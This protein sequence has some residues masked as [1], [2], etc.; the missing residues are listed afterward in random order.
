MR[1]AKTRTRGW[2]YWSR[3]FSNL[4]VDWKTGPAQMALGTRPFVLFFREVLGVCMAFT[5]GIFYLFLMTIPLVFQ[6]TYDQLPDIAGLH[7]IAIS[8]AS[9]FN[10]RAVDRIYA[11]LKSRN[12]DNGTPEYRLRAYT[13]GSRPQLT[14]NG[15]Y[16][17][18]MVARTLLL[19]AGLPICI[20]G[21]SSSF[22]ASLKP[23]NNALKRN[24]L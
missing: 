10:A 18:S 11:Y 5:R 8:V 14:Y 16:T 23:T 15:G 17:V 9:Q 21:C 1:A 19:P 3:R 24:L 20:N 13:F 22:P 4:V 7:Y 2:S 12:G 6:V